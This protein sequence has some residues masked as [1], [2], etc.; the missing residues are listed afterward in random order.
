MP[1]RSSA[2][3]SAAFRRSSSSSWQSKRRRKQRTERDG[4]TAS[5]SVGDSS[6]RIL[7]CS[8]RSR[9]RSIAAAN[10]STP[11]AQSE[12]HTFSARDVRESWIPRSARLTS[13][14]SAIASWRYA[15]V[16]SNARRRS[17]TSRTSRQPHSYGWYSHLWGSS[18]TESAGRSRGAPA[19]RARSDRE[20]AVGRVHVEPE[21]ELAAHVGELVERIDRCGVR[22]ASVCRDEEREPPRSLVRFDRA[23]QGPGREPAV[24]A[25]AGRGS[26]RA[27]SRA[28]ARRGRATNA[29]DRRRRRRDARSSRRRP[30]RA[31]HASAVMFA[32]EPPLRSVP[33][34]PCGRPIQPRNHRAPRARAA[35]GRR[36][37]S[38]SPRR[39]CTRSR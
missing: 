13:S 31:R 22:R 38:T 18:V 23:A 32:A 37:P 16:I 20:A 6:I 21:A 9:Q 11:N 24:G 2:A 10:A 33:P 36:P 14:V 17:A 39:C 27:G 5:S 28:R 4:A 15:G 1:L 25:R 7:A 19:A 12:S 35:S 34:A 3:T 8:A 29:P 26:D 30:T